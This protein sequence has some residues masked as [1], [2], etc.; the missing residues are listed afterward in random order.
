MTQPNPT[1]HLIAAGI[2]RRTPTN[3]AVAQRLR[4]ARLLAQCHTDYTAAATRRAHQDHR[5]DIHP[6]TTT[7]KRSAL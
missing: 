7:S 3:A 6:C 2:V 5:D 1:R 4:V